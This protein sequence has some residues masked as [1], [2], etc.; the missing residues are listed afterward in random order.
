MGVY[1]QLVQW[2]QT[3]NLTIVLYAFFIFTCTTY[4]GERKQFFHNFFNSV[5]IENTEYMFLGFGRIFGGTTNWRE[6]F[7]SA[8]FISLIRGSYELL[9]YHS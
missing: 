2:Q 4:Q 5:S 6:K 1:A 8:F 7:S 9:N 3:E